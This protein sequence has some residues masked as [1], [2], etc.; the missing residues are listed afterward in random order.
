MV[1]GTI[2]SSSNSCFPNFF[3]VYG[4][5]KIHLMETRCGN[6][7]KVYAPKSFLIKLIMLIL[8]QLTLPISWYR[9]TTA[10]LSSGFFLLGFFFFSYFGL[11]QN[12]AG[13]NHLQ[14]HYH[15]YIVKIALESSLIS[16][17]KTK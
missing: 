11:I 7:P 4:F 10:N 2:R 6:A 3:I 17:N 8:T 9:N 5:L 13:S 1:A 15:K 12:T 14:G 16:K